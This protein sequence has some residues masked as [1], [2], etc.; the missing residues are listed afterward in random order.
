MIMCWNVWSILNDNKLENFLQIIQDSNISIACVTETWFDSKNGTFSQSIKRCGYELHHAYR[1]KKRGG[2][3]AILYRKQLMVKEGGASSSKFTS[4]EYVCV[5]VTLQAKKRLMLMCVYRKQEVAFSSF[6]LEFGGLMDKLLNRGEMMLIVG[7]FYVW[8]EVEENSEAQKLT[9]LMNA[10]GL[11]Q[12]VQ[13]PTHREGHT[14]D[15]VYVNECELELHH[16]V[17]SET[18]GLVTDHLPIK[19]TIPSP[20]TQN[21]NKVI[22]YRKLK[23]V[24]VEAFR[25][26]LRESLEQINLNPCFKDSYMQFDETSRKVVEKHSPL[27]TR[28][29]RSVGAVWMDAE[30]RRNRAKRRKLEKAWKKNRTEENMKNYIEQKQ[31]CTQL[32]LSKQTQHYS[33]LIEGA[34]NSQQS[35]FKVA[36]ELLDKNS[37][38]I[39]PTHNDPK[40]LANEF[41]DFFVEKVKLIR[42]SIPEVKDIPSYYSRPFEGEKVTEFQPTTEEEVRELINEHGVKTC[43]EDPIPSKLFK[44]ALD[45]ILPVIVKLINISLS[46]GSI[47]GVNWS[48]VDLLLKKFRLDFDAKKHYRPYLLYFSKI[49]E[50][51]VSIRT[52][53]HMDLNN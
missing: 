17:V 49:T 31:I 51:V 52:E 42:E 2:G 39:L 1:D 23:D 6:E 4:F 18:F 43:A 22:T 26:D 14:L 13:E 30:Y 37:K 16:E 27:Q 29:V 28:T 11:S 8:A 15:H 7:D 44:A 33:K 40:A 21:E 12:I 47:N 41:N 24:N 5:S 53:E 46:E 10:C 20:P 48:V 35:L 9:T 3:V 19:I 34:S 45:I 25:E 36:N 38:K 50:R 32:A